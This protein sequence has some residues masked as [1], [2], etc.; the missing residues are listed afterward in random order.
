MLLVP[1]SKVKYFREEI[2]QVL[3]AL[4]VFRVFSY[5]GYCEYSQQQYLE[6]LRCGYS[7]S[8]PTAFRGSLL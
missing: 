2:L 8:G 6:V 3:D 5:C 1:G 7:S 4:A